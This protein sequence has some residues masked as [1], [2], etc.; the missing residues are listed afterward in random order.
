MGG[1]E[2][3][4]GSNEGCGADTAWRWRSMGRRQRLVILVQ[5]GAD[6]GGKSTTMM[7]AYPFTLC[8]RAVAVTM[9]QAASNLEF[10][11]EHHWLSD[12]RNVV[13]LNLT[14]RALINVAQNLHRRDKQFGSRPKPPTTQT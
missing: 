8:R 14:E 9:D 7:Y 6:C 13:L 1:G 3:R 12:P 5:T 2:R 11:K 4:G 10:F